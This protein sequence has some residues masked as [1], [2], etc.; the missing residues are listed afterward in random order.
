MRPRSKGDCVTVWQCDCVTDKCWCD[1]SSREQ[2]WHCRPSLFISS[3]S[4][5][6]TLSVVQGNVSDFPMGKSTGTLSFIDRHLF[7]GSNKI[8]KIV[9]NAK[10]HGNDYSLPISQ[11]TPLNEAH[12]SHGNGVKMRWLWWLKTTA[13][14]ND[15][16]R[17]SVLLFWKSTGG[18][19]QGTVSPLFL[20]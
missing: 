9:L 18:S 3:P 11:S 8:N 13:M 1:V 12:F 5:L 2:S 4:P 15:K 6:T 16:R 17:D 14:I 19:A 10:V 7:Q 20:L